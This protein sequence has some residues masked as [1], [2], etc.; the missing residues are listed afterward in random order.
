MVLIPDVVDAVA[1]MPV[2]AAGGIGCG[3]QM[4]S[5]AIALGAEGVWTGSIWLTVTEAEASPV[6]TEKLLHATLARHRAL[7]LA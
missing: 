2:L 6:L 1:P 7:A 3:R 4:A 5:P